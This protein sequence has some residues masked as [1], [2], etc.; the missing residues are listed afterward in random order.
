[1]KRI[2]LPI[3]LFLLLL[4]VV[5]HR[6]LFF[7]EAFLPL[8]QL[9]Y[10]RPWSAG[11]AP[12]ARPS[13]NP[14]HYDSVGQYWVFRD[15]ATRSLRGN[16]LPLWNPY[17]LCGT[18]FI[19]NNLSA[20]YYPGNILHL[21]LG[22]D[23]A[24]GWSA[25]LHLLLAAT[26]TYFLMRRLGHSQWA[27]TLAGLVYGFSMWQI[28][29]LHL[30][31]FVATSAWLPAL[32]LSMLRLRERV[33][34][35]RAVVVGI[36]LALV[37]T[38]GHLQIAFYVVLT[39]WAFAFWL[40]ARDR[41][42]RAIFAT[43]VLASHM[44]AVLMAAPQLL[45]TLELARY[46]HRT[47][48]ATW[49]SY[50]AY[51]AYAAHPASLVT[52]FVPDFF[53]NPS[54]PETPYFGFSRSGVYYNYAEGALYVGLL[55]LLL[56]ALKLTHMRRSPGARLPIIIG[57]AALLIGMGTPLTAALYFGV[58]GFAGSGSPARIYILW[59]F[60]AAWSAASGWDALL[61]MP[62][63]SRAL[64]WS[65]VA[66]LTVIALMLAAATMTTSHLLGSTPLPA[67]EIVR[68]AT[69]LGISAFALLL[70]TKP[71]QRRKGMVL[72]LL[73]L[74]VDL[75]SHAVPYNSTGNPN[76]VRGNRALT[77][78]IKDMAAHDRA[79]VLNSD[80]RFSGP[81]AVLPPNL[82]TLFSFRDMQGYDSLLPG[83]YKRWLRR[84]LGDDPSPPEVGNVVFVK[85]AVPNLF[86]KAGVRVVVSLSPLALGVAPSYEQDGVYVYA[87]PHVS[88]R[89]VAITQDGRPSALHWL[90][91]EP[92][93]L[94]LAVDL[95]R[96]G[97]LEVRDQCW[98]G[99]HAYARGKE[100]PIE[101]HD[102]VF[103]RVHLPAG[104]SIVEFR[105]EP[106]TTLLG[107]YCLCLGVAVTAAV[108]VGT[109]VKPVS[110]AG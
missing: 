69:I 109:R 6:C 98:P 33:S 90:R 13:W 70:L 100:R 19:A 16:T 55:P 21:F 71:R 47:A 85:R 58:P 11:V 105:Y 57:A 44:L 42:G 99:W 65:V 40:L 32:C 92:N 36:V 23:R 104:R 61:Q 84:E 75:L 51:V 49:E 59:C 62:T 53:G 67:V 28:T 76:A 37:L 34:I 103:R 87:L 89:A 38:A 31:P 30:P 101:R 15:F 5:F 45:P 48:A 107:V 9:S 81:E 97:F 4:A 82:A 24:V 26:F 77:D 20:V 108:L 2:A 91:D 14:L 41:A 18:P 52:L 63:P 8:G 95:P 46:G 64:F 86:S 29:W 74:S 27:S 43:T 106:T 102:T 83:L 73:V 68:Q 54:S 25:A 56:L 96:S 110:V 66:T 50:S 22:T 35:A 39:G 93:C 88:G 3:L 79:A 7:G 17:Q 80:W 72:G 78:A 1:V 10:L 94:V 60:A 12:E